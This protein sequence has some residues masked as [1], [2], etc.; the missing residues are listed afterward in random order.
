MDIVPVTMGGMNFMGHTCKFVLS[1]V[2]QLY[3][4]QIVP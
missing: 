2:N 4:F 1:H 3:H